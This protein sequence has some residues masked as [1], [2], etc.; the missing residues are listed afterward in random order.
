MRSR[1]RKKNEQR[2]V[3]TGCV[4]SFVFLFRIGLTTITTFIIPVQIQPGVTSY[5]HLQ[6]Y[7]DKISRL[8]VSYLL[9]TFCKNSMKWDG[10]LLRHRLHKVLLIDASKSA[11]CNPFLHSSPVITVITISPPATETRRGGRE[12]SGGGKTAGEQQRRKP[13]RKKYLSSQGE[14]SAI[15]A[16]AR[17]FTKQAEQWWKMWTWM[18]VRCLCG[19]WNGGAREAWTTGSI[20]QR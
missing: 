16:G 10:G 19:I 8:Q 15:L 7:W 13:G 14:T 3:W 5:S 11:T 2:C 17:G 12:E 9:E 6:T 18:S 4:T 20:Q 1:G